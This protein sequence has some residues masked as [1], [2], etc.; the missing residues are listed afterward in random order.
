MH[1]TAVPTHVLSPNKRMFGAC[2]VRSL[3][4]TFF[5]LW[6][7]DAVWWRCVPEK[8]TRVLSFIQYSLDHFR[9]KQ[10]GHEGQVVWVTRG[11]TAVARCAHSPAVCVFES[12]LGVHGHN[13]H[14]KRHES[15]CVC[16]TPHV[17]PFLYSIPVPT[18]ISNYFHG[19]MSGRSS[20]ELP[21]LARTTS[22]AQPRNLVLRRMSYCGV[23]CVRRFG[24]WAVVWV[25]S[26]SR[27]PKAN[28]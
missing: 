23:A 24:S 8:T 16:S 11:G 12:S 7:L 9:P 6:A 14:R 26:T 18:R 17:D 4:W 1:K 10:N 20:C 21:T 2:S 19:L 5:A 25:P 3:S 22:T 28:S 27:C 13:G 15:V